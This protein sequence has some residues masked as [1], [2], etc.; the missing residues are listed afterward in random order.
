MQI[1]F[2]RF[3]DPD[4]GEGLA[5]DPGKF[6]GRCFEAW[7]YIPELAAILEASHAGRG[8]PLLYLPDVEIRACGGFNV[9]EATPNGVDIRLRQSGAPIKRILHSYKFN[10][11]IISIRPLR[12]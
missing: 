9:T 6:V 4:V 11:F 8:E 5:R 3:A 2:Q 10:M 12:P 1:E 7:L